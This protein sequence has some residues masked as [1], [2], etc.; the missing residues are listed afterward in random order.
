MLQRHILSG[1]PQAAV[2]ACDVLPACTAFRLHHAQRLSAL[3]ALV[4]RCY[5]QS[6]LV[7]VCN[8]STLPPLP[9]AS[10]NAAAIQD[11]QYPT[12]GAMSIDWQ[13]VISQQKALQ[14]QLPAGA[15]G[16]CAGPAGGA[17][18]QGETRWHAQHAHHPAY[19]DAAPCKLR[20]AVLISTGSLLSTCV[21][22]YQQP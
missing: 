12:S 19:H 2:A 22:Q 11:G 8:T 5:N 10:I 4:H 3:S 1:C 16:T 9:L 14:L 18:L 13:R 17:M 21:M 15:P 20:A 7:Q 6:T